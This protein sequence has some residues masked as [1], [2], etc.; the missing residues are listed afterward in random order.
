MKK[1]NFEIKKLEETKF[2][3]KSKAL[4]PR[5]KKKKKLGESIKSKLMSLFRKSTPTKK[6]KP[7][8][9]ETTEEI[10]QK[11]SRRTIAKKTKKST[12]KEK[13]K[14]TKVQSIKK[15]EMPRTKETK[16]KKSV[17]PV[18]KKN[19]KRTEREILNSVTVAEVMKK[20]EIMD[21]ES[22]IVKV[23]R[24]F[25]EKKCNGIFISK[26]GKVKGLII[27]PDILDVLRKKKKIAKLKAGDIMSEFIWVNKED[28]LSKAILIMH[29]HNSGCVA[30][31]NHKE[32]VGVVTRSG[33]L[34]KMARNI[35]ST[36]NEGVVG[37][38]IETKVDKLLDLLRKK[39]TNMKELKEKLNLDEEKIEEW[40]EILEDHDLI[41]YKKSLFGKISVE[42]VK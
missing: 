26:K 41:K 25:S 21:I 32:V 29:L 37:N 42:Y 11:K 34:N 18:K 35:F 13:G 6:I 10:K 27:L 7:T 14:T 2:A 28:S 4:L 23:V 30:V 1:S 5:N 36:K 17:I 24:R 31:M 22:P 20:A 40:L 8:A 15:N 38:I 16:T 33:I 39:E 12:A 3:N 9:K 19:T